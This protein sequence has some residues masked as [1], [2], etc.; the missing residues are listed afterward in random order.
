[1]EV[2][3]RSGE[4]GACPPEKTSVWILPLKEP[5][6]AIARAIVKSEN[7]IESEDCIEAV[8]GGDPVPS[9]QR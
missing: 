5:A 1:M 2:I 9:G 7:C 4:N 6:R 8:S 3:I